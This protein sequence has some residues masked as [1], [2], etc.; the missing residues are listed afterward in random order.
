[1]C[2][3]TLAWNKNLELRVILPHDHGFISD[4]CQELN[5]SRES[6]LITR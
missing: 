2:L 3:K 5:M 1:M 4:S 6:L